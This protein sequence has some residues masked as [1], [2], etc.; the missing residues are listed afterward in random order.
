MN[1][2]LEFTSIYVK[3]VTCENCLLR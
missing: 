1:V 3:H 2:L